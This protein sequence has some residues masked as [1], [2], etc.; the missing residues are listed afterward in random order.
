M[1]ASRARTEPESPLITAHV[2]W[3]GLAGMT[4]RTI[5]DRREWLARLDEALPLGLGYASAE[6]LHAAI[7]SMAARAKR[8][9]S[10]QTLSTYSRHTRM[11]YKWAIVDACVLAEPDPSV[12]L[13]KPHVPARQPRPVRDDVLRRILTEVRDPYRI[14]ARLAAYAGLRC[15][16]ISRLH[17][18]HVDADGI[19]IVAG[20]GEQPGWV[21]MHPE[22]WQSVEPL[23]PG[24]I[25]RKRRSGEPVNDGEYVSSMW[26]CHLGSRGIPVGLHQLRHWYGTQTLRHTGNLRTAQRLLRHKNISST[27]GYTEILSEELTAAVAALPR[28]GDVR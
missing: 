28:L 12:S 17:R 20:K 18:E 16:E 26:R 2:A 9:W 6:E 27:V 7:G 14:W 25:V 3:M 8:E 22:I 19:R 10:R 1:K 24:P 11:F 15:I 23:P 13:P 21:P 4:K 5:Q